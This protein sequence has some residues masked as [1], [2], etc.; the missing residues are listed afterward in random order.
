MVSKTQKKYIG[1]GKSRK[2]KTTRRSRT[3]NN[4]RG[5]RTNTNRRSRTNTNR[6]SRTNTNRRSRTNTNIRSSTYKRKQDKYIKKQ[7]KIVAVIEKYI[8]W[9]KQQQITTPTLDLILKNIKSELKN[10]KKKKNLT[11]IKKLILFLI[12]LSYNPLAPEINENK[13]V[14]TLGTYD[15][16]VSMSNT[17]TLLD[18]HDPRLNPNRKIAFSNKEL[19]LLNQK[20]KKLYNEIKNIIDNNN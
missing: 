13:S 15:H 16:T 8:E 1:S 5:S 11:K 14:T 18:Y 12:L 10:I 19:K 2:G 4:T 3:K 17:K 7:Q 9:K 6:R 20:N